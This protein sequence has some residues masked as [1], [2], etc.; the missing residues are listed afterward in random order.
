MASKGYRITEVSVNHRLR[1][2]GKSKYGCSRFLTGLLDILT[3][4]LII[5]FTNRP[6]HLFG[7][8]ALGM[9]VIGIFSELI[10]V[11][12]KVFLG[13]LFITHMPIMIFGVM[14]I[15]LGVSF[16]GIGLL[17]ELIV[18]QKKSENLY[19]IDKN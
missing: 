4:K 12:Y 18:H 6:S 2:S 13:H 1:N 14:T 5:D 8:V 9:I 3:M 19:E 7:Y 10:A 11:F 16:F 17:G 15:I